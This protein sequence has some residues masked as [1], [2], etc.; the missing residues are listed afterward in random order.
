MAL[1]KFL[2]PQNQLEKGGRSAAPVQQDA[3][4][5]EKTCPN[6][7]RQTPLSRLWGNDLVCACGYHFRMKARQRIRMITDPGSFVE[8]FSALRSEN[9]L[10]FPGYRDKIE[11][12]QAASR[13][14]EAVL[15]GIARI[16]GQP[17][18]LFVMERYLGLGDVLWVRRLH[19]HLP[20][21]PQK[22]IQTGY[23]TSVAPLS[24][25]D[26]EN[27]DPGVWIPSPHILNEL[28]FL[29]RVL[30]WMAVGTM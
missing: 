1:I 29:R 8:M 23:G 5:P 6:C 11:T 16:A 27:D 30:V 26:P 12:V 18:Y 21:L 13:E 28:D 2:K 25:L 14:G 7:H 9:P 17:C 3:G 22:T 24:E 10:D 15:C 19:C 20:S 4:E